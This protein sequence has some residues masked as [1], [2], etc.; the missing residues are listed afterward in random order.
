MKAGHC[1]MGRN[2]PSP[3]HYGDRFSQIILVL[4]EI[5]RVIITLFT[6]PRVINLLKTLLSWAVPL[7]S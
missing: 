2:G 6:I 4:L 7:F 3:F 5:H 1:K